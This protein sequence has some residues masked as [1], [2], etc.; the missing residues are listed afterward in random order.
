MCIRFRS[1]VSTVG[2]LAFLAHVSGAQNNADRISRIQANLNKAKQAYEQLPDQVKKTAR[3][4]R[5]LAHLADAVNRMAGRLGKMAP[6]QPWSDDRTLSDAADEN[7]LVRVNNPAR[8]FRFS[9]FLGYT[10][11]S[12]AIARCG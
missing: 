7:G 3:A 1:L 9:Q 12:T 8:D 2:L 11:S 6:G 10:Q 5:R 4:Q